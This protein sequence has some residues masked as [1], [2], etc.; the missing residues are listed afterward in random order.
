MTKKAH[1]TLKLV[2]PE[3]QQTLMNV[4]NPEYDSPEPFRLYAFALME[5]AYTLDPSIFPKGTPDVFTD[6]K[7]RQLGLY[8]AFSCSAKLFEVMT[9]H[10][11][12]LFPEVL[13]TVMPPTWN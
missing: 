13:A 2:E 12:S 11:K 10:I 5:K 9:D 6:W 4:F 7:N 3:A 1:S 8:G